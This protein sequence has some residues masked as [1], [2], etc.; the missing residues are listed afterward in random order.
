M[1]VATEI[2]NNKNNKFAQ[3]INIRV[4]IGDFGTKMLSSELHE[5]HI[6]GTIETIDQEA[7]EELSN[8]VDE[9]LDVDGEPGIVEREKELSEEETKGK[10]KWEPHNGRT[11]TELV[12]NDAAEDGEYRA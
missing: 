11:P 4:E 2:I 9:I 6:S 3:N 12:T 5:E 1:P 10:R 8:R 7:D